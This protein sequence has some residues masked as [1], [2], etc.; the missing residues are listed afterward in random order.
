MQNPPQR[1][2]KSLDGAWTMLARAKSLRQRPDV[3]LSDVRSFQ[4]LVSGGF[5]CIR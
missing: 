1:R 4:P 3:H 5:G 2:E